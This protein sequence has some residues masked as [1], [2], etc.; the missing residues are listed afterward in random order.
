MNRNVVIEDAEYGFS[1]CH[2]E[3]RYFLETPDGGFRAVN[4]AVVRLLEKVARGEIALSALRTQAEGG[5]AVIDESHTSAEEALSLVEGYVEQGILS[6]GDP[7]VEIVPPDDVAL[8]PYVAGFLVLLSVFG[9]AVASIVSN[10]S[11]AVVREVSVGHLA[12]TM[13]LSAAYLGIHEYGHYA[14]SDRHFDPSVRFDFVNGVVPA[15]VT[16]TTGS[17]MLPRNWRILINLAGP[18]VELA[19]GLPLVALHYL[20]PQSLLA[21]ILVVSVFAHVVL[22][23]NP[24]IHG[25][26][27][28][29]LCDYFGLMNVRPK[30]IEDLTDLR[31]SWS[32]A[33]VVVSYG[34]G[35]LVAVYM[36]VM[37]ASFVGLVEVSLP[38]GFA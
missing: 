19:A 2:V 25:D 31:P 20:Y 3:G 37:L 38:I 32:A 23:L 22:S 17:W 13:V 36:V 30:G 11:V 21:Q 26:G 15:V 1:W 33:Y 6:E 16:D 4:E 27:F 29:I 5:E 34:F 9:L 18:L 14:L 7:V 10:A 28:W 24:L 35:A 8:W 12:V